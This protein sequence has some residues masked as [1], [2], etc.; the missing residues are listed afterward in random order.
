MG[1]PMPMPMKPG[2][3]GAGAALKNIDPRMLKILLA[4]MMKAK[5]GGGAPMPG[6][7]GAPMPGGGGMPSMM[8]R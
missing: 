8:G 7:G 2:M 4:Q 6:S 3:K 5:Q 1:M